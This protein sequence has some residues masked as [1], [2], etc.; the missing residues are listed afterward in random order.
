M[1]RE[2]E[3]EMEETDDESDGGASLD[4]S[5]Q[6]RVLKVTESVGELNKLEHSTIVAR[7]CL[8]NMFL[9]VIQWLL[10]ALPMRETGVG[11]FT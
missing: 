1:E 7:M 2:R 6:V 4:K 8:L 5:S 10:K 3:F 9:E 11:H